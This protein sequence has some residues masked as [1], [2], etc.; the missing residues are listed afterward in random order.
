MLQ[1]LF[2]RSV[3]HIEWMSFLQLGTMMEETVPVY[4]LAQ[5]RRGTKRSFLGLWKFP[6]WFGNLIHRNQSSIYWIIDGKIM[7]YTLPKHRK[8]SYW[9]HIAGDSYEFTVN[10]LQNAAWLVILQNDIHLFFIVRA[11]HILEGWRMASSRLSC[12]GMCTYGPSVL[13]VGRAPILRSAEFIGRSSDKFES[14][15]Y[16]HIDIQKSY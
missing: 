3:V 14:I 11:E 5:Y 2:N 12:T 15:I 9:R 13:F 1:S 6:T 16:M 8:T 10:F 7:R 4:G